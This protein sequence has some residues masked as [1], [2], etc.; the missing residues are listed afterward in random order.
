MNCHGS[1]NQENNNNSKG[2]NGHGWHMLL[3]LLCC[4]IP[5][6]LLAMLSALRINS[7]ILG[8]ILPF[9]ALLLCPLMHI[10]MIPMMFRKEMK[11][12]KPAAHD[13]SP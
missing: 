7:P 11:R 2:H 3:M 8:K 9:G 4:A 6:A 10:L 13:K 1:N 12:K 5:L